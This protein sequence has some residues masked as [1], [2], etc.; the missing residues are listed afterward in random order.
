MIVIDKAASIV[1]EI[2]FVNE[3]DGR[4]LPTKYII[5]AICCNDN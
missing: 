3:H 2:G 1:E 4:S 5:R